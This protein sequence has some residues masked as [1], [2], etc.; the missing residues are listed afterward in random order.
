M[1]HP[2]IPT[3]EQVYTHQ[4]PGTGMEFRSYQGFWEGDAGK[5]VLSSDF[6][7]G[8]LLSVPRGNLVSFYLIAHYPQLHHYVHAARCK[9]SGHKFG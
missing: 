4:D 2:E 1:L 8:A 9:I 7:N 6:G 3:A 5:L